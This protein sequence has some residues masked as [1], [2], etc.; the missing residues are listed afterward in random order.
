MSP[1]QCKWPGRVHPEHQGMR[2]VARLASFVGR[3]ANWFAGRHRDRALRCRLEPAHAG[4]SRASSGRAAAI[5]PTQDR[6]SHVAQLQR[7]PRTSELP[8][9]VI[10]RAARTAASLPQLRI[11]SLDAWG[12]QAASGPGFADGT[13]LA[14]GDDGPPAM[15]RR[16]LRP[17]QSADNRRG[18]A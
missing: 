13:A 12:R 8:R 15:V 4:G 9:P 3:C 14:A 10:L 2:A 1:V 7:P 11:P 6:A 17:T 18:R 5:A 16:S